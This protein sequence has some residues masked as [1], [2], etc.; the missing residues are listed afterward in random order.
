MRK[1]V[2]LFL[3]V[4]LLFTLGCLFTGRLFAPPPPSSN[5]R[6]TCNNAGVTASATVSVC[7]TAACTPG[8]PAIPCAPVA[9]GGALPKTGKTT[10][11]PGFPPLGVTL[12]P[13]PL[14]VTD[15][16]GTLACMGS[17]PLPATTTCTAP[18]SGT[19]TLKASK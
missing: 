10:C 5:I 4:G 1:F 11:A 17:F 19:A 13:G 18:A 3:V 16:G 8:T 7:E 9:C 6:L 15:G 14:T 2:G 12:F